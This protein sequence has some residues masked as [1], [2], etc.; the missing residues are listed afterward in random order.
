VA[1]ST[2]RPAVALLGRL[3]GKAYALL[4]PGCDAVNLV[5]SRKFSPSAPNASCSTTDCMV[6]SALEK[7][8]SIW[9]R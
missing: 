5:V 3:F 2:R 8:C 1:I 4:L 7:T 6:P 9:N